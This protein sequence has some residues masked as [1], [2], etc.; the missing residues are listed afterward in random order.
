MAA[1]TPASIRYLGVAGGI[2]EI[3]AR[4]TSV[5]DADTWA[6]GLKG[7]ITWTATDRTGTTTSGV[8][9]SESS[10]TFTFKVATNGKAVDLVVKLRS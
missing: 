10:A 6:S 8:A 9:A 1:I 5:D 3:L 4:F 7:I 2:R